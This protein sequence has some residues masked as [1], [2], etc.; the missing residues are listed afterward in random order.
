MSDSPLHPSTTP[1]GPG[2]SGAWEAAPWTL[3][4]NHNG[5]GLVYRAQIEG[6][7]ARVVHCT[8]FQ[9]QRNRAGRFEPATT[10][11]SVKSTSIESP[12]VIC[13]FGPTYAGLSPETMIA[14]ADLCNAAPDLYEA[15][16]LCRLVIS[17]WLTFP[18]KH[19]HI[20]SQFAVMRAVE[21]L[22]K[23][24]PQRKPDAQ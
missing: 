5:A 22:Q 13:E 16:E 4:L 7:Q 23:A 18:E 19:N 6:A 1:E 2:K 3:H 10:P 14:N 12:A 17:H 20:D 8:T 9:G 24:N 11:G 15:L 21:A